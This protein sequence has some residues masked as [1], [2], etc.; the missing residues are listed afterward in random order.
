MGLFR[1]AES[2]GERLVREFEDLVD[3][4][5]ARAQSRA[6]AVEHR[7]AELEAEK[8]HIGGL[9]RRLGL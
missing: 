9:L 3:V 7:L 1:S 4:I 8:G 2:E 6:Q 5:S